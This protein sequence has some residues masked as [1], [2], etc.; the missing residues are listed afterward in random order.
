[1]FMLIWVNCN[2]RTPVSLENRARDVPPLRGNEV[3]PSRTP[4]TVH[5]CRLIEC[6]VHVTDRQTLSWAHE[7]SW[8]LWGYVLGS[9]VVIF[10]SLSGKTCFPCLKCTLCFASVNETF[11]TATV[12]EPWSVKCEEWERSCQNSVSLPA[13]QILFGGGVSRTFL[14][15][16]LW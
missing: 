2:N 5:S 4:L 7:S 9:C 15:G 3:S 8:R 10:C 11:P 12:S 13:W 1:M 16:F 14:E 6:E